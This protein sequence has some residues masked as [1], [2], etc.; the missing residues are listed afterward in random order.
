[1]APIP[2][3]FGPTKSLIQLEGGPTGSASYGAHAVLDDVLH[4][5]RKFKIQTV[6][7]PD[8]TDQIGASV[9]NSSM[10][11]ADAFPDNNRH[12]TGYAT[13]ANFVPQY[14]VSTTRD[15]G[16]DA[17]AA[18]MAVAAKNHAEEAKKAAEEAEIL[19]AREKETVAAM[20]EK[21]TALEAKAAKAETVVE[22]EAVAKDI[23]AL[24]KS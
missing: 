8:V 2:G 22:K 17:I 4:E 12:I 13:P 5:D 10:E 7:G 24:E 16:D 18:S 15:A 21:K 6:A 14:G 1:M 23:A 9:H 19:A 20:A 11:G 3:P